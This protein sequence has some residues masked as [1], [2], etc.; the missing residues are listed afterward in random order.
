MKLRI[1]ATLLVAIGLLVGGYYAY[2]FLNNWKNDR[3]IEH[4]CLLFRNAEKISIRHY[5]G[6]GRHMARDWGEGSLATKDVAVYIARPN[7]VNGFVYALTKI[8]KNGYLDL[9]RYAAATIEYEYSIALDNSH[10]NNLRF[11]YVREVPTGML[12]YSASTDDETFWGTFDLH[13]G[14]AESLKLLLNNEFST[15]KQAVIERP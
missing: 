7:E 11:V 3:Y 5:S 6:I 1:I 10:S 9:N 2:L 8:I 15:R 14:A 12:A 4:L 13:P